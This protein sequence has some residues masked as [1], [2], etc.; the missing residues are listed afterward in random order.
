MGSGCGSVGKAVDP[1]TKDP[2]FESSHWQTFIKHLF[3]VNCV[4]KTKITKNR[5]GMAHLKKIKNNNCHSC[6]LENYVIHDSASFSS[7]KKWSFQAS[8]SLFFIFSTNS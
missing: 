7:A 8:F 2:W 4:E 6:E 1:N 3:T 5:P